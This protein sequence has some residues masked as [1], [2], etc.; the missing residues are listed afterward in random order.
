MN[1]VVGNLSIILLSVFGV[2]LVVVEMF[3]PGI[4][5][6]GITGILMLFVAVG[7][8]FSAYGTVWG[9]LAA[10]AVVLLIT[11]A[12]LIS[13][14][15]A[16]K[17]KLSRSRLF[18]RD[19]GGEQPPQPEPLDLIGKTGVTQTPLRP[20]GIILLNGERKSVVT[21]GGFIE[22][23]RTVRI[24]HVNGSRIIVEETPGT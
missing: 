24:T 8:V 7:M 15:S 14:H 22:A 21:E 13:L 20:S 2:G 4:G 12:L 16:N 11:A 1:D 9:L 18:L 17:G 19:N 5:L 3:L 23:G 6:P 10:L